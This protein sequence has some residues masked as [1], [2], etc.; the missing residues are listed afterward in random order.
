[1]YGGN[2]IDIFDRRLLQTYI[3][4]YLG[5]FVF[6]TYQPFQFHGSENGSERRRSRQHNHQQ[7]EQE[8]QRQQQ[9]QHHHRDN[10]ND[11]GN[12]GAGASNA[13]SPVITTNYTIPYEAT[14]LH[15]FVGMIIT[16]IYRIFTLH[17]GNAIYTAT[18]HPAPSTRAHTQRPTNTQKVSQKCASNQCTKLL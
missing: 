8:Q 3:R 5:D 4:E 10:G 11:E 6:N 18:Q 1:M 14:M 7:Q 15:D 13:I 2:I 12:G 9:Q 16:S 17:Y